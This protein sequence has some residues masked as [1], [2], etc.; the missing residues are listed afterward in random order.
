MADQNKN[1]GFIALY[2][3]IQ[4]HWLW[5]ADKTT[6]KFQ[7][8]IDLILTVNYQDKKFMFNGKLTE[9]KRGSWI[10]SIA[11][12]CKRWDWS[13][14]K[15]VKF[16]DELE[17]DGMIIR[18]SDAKKTVITI[19]NYGVYQ[20]FDFQENDAET[21]QK[22][23]RGDA[24]TFQKHFKNVQL[25]KDNK[26]N[27]ETKINNDNNK[28]LCTELQDSSMQNTKLF[29]ELILNDKTFYQVTEED[30]DSWSMLY[31]AVDVKQDL[32]KMKGWLESNPSKRKT[33]RGIRRFI[34]NWL[35]RT[36]DQGGTKGY[37]PE[38]V[39]RDYSKYEDSLAKAARLRAERGLQ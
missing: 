35:S 7:A 26:D 34:T 11:Q 37:Q 29:I 23:F 13:N 32:R 19:V 31:P 33:R 30:V 39:K 5:S 28:E 24:E 12:L 15:V 3:S 21:F 9:V 22:H 4:E 25:N 10:T 14:S 38:P 18:K 1:K 20:D 2:R 36:Q 16:L 6:S 17:K 27:K 8:W